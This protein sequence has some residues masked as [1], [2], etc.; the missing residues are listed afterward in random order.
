M[1][2]TVDTDQ[3]IL[4]SDDSEQ[5]SKLI[6][7][8]SNS[9]SNTRSHHL[10]SEEVSRDS[11]AENGPAAVMSADYSSED[12]C[13]TSSVEDSRLVGSCE[14]ESCEEGMVSCDESM[15]SRDE[16]TGSRDD[17]M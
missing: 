9:I 1:E 15:V 11:G 17:S 8:L 6:E 2:D 4:L 5:L 14:T 12:M 16:N 10:S 7:H 13:G 3:D